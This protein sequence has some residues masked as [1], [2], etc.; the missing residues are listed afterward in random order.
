MGLI[1]GVSRRKRRTGLFVLSFLF[2]KKSLDCAR[3]DKTKKDATAIPHA[4]AS[5]TKTPRVA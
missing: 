4:R 2:C 3:E 1:L 5:I